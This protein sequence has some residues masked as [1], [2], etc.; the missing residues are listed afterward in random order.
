[1]ATTNGTTRGPVRFYGMNACDDCRHL[2]ATLQKNAIPY[3]FLDITDL[4]TLRDFLELRDSSAEFDEVRAQ[5]RVGIPCLVRPD[6]S[7]THD[8]RDELG[9]APDQ[10]ASEQEDAAVLAQ[11]SAAAGAPRG[12]AAPACSLHGDHSGC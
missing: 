8:W 5:G 2:K 10:E 6:G 3:E 7:C 11:A 4:G 12:G 9:I 1:M